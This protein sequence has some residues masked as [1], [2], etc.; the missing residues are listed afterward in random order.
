MMNLEKLLSVL[1]VP[2][3]VA[4]LGALALAVLVLAFFMWVLPWRHLF[5]T[6]PQLVLLAMIGAGGYYG[7]Y[8]F[9]D[10][11][12]L[13]ER[14]ALEDR[15]SALFGQTIQPG[16]VL[17]CIDGSPA[18]AMFEA[19]E[20]ALFA[21]PQRVA[22]AVAIVTQRISYLADALHFAS[23][24]DAGYLDRI[25]PL[26]KA[27]EADPYGFIAYVLA[28]EYHCT[29]EACERFKLL[30]DPARVKENLRVRRFEA[31]MI[32][33]SAAWREP[34]QR[35]VAEGGSSS[36]L[37][38]KEAGPGDALSSRMNKLDPGASSGFAPVPANVGAQPGVTTRSTVPA[39]PINRPAATRPQSAAPN[40]AGPQQTPAARA[41]K[42]KEKN[43][44][45]RRQK[46]PVAGL[47]RV[48][49]RDYLPEEKEEPPT[50][51][52]G[53]VGAP[54]SI[55]PPQQNLIDR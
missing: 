44:A 24:R 3:W 46:E 30:R 48:V 40:S 37:G 45:F 1:P 8:Y 42:D 19:C 28:N 31:F 26:R 41:A 12:R 13:A 35:P 38:D 36:L 52:S 50:Q 15:A 2:L 9:E 43:T 39:A 4:E 6:L 17:S 54:T 55:A 47:P 23:A 14:R 10:A 7:Y 21:E 32:K 34:S 20:R 16:S 29:L 22:A 11:S 25:E 49:P 18:P 27:I 53:T 33:H 51:T 5:G